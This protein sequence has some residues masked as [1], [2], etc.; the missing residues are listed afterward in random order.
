[1]TNKIIKYI[2]ISADSVLIFRTKK[3]SH[4]YLKPQYIL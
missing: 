3:K 2:K 1:M 4:F